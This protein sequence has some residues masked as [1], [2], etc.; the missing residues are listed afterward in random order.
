MSNQNGLYVSSQIPYG[1]YTISAGFPGQNGQSCSGQTSSTLSSP[2]QSVTINISC[3][4]SD[5]SPTT[6]V[7]PSRT[8]SPT[9]QR[10]PSPYPSPTPIGNFSINGKVLLSNT[11]TPLANVSVSLSVDASRS[12]TATTDSNGNYSMSISTTYWPAIKNQRI[13]F[14]KINYKSD[15]TYYLYSLASQISSVTA[16]GSYQ[17]TNAYMSIDPANL[18]VFGSVKDQNNNLLF[19]A[20]VDVNSCQTS[21][22]GGPWSGMSDARVVQN[23]DLISMNPSTNFFITNIKKPTD[24][25]HQC[26][27]IGAS[28]PGYTLVSINGTSAT[29]DGFRYTA[30]T[31]GSNPFIN[32]NIILRDNN[33]PL[34]SP[35]PSPVPSPSP[36]PTI[37]PSRTPF[38][39][40]TA[41]V[42]SFGVRGRVVDEKKVP[43]AGVLISISAPS[44]NNY[45]AV[46]ANDGSYSINNIMFETGHILNEYSVS[47]VKIGYPWKGNETIA[48]LL[49]SLPI[50]LGELNELYDIELKQGTNIFTLYGSVKDQNN[51]LLD[52]INLHLVPC[53]RNS[54]K[55]R[56]QTII[57]KISRV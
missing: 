26:I 1:S 50:K 40:P 56:T 20:T 38:P 12:Y 9:P 21:N 5:S 7:T 13:Y 28:K 55:F 4:G 30:Y 10:S 42:S 37:T 52:H 45:S 49:K 14:D 6:S 11:T 2:S 48:G 44:G 22:G 18:T 8:P 31:S 51:V 34:A 35:T 32:L 17:L 33:A 3:S 16:G 24:T 46:S 29:Y 57:S 36:S 39:T 19:E 54:W 53:D 41:S 23:A 47:T 43:L 25:L 27:S 15:Q